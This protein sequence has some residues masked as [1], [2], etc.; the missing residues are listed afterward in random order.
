MAII[1]SFTTYSQLAHLGSRLSQSPSHVPPP[2]FSLTCPCQAGILTGDSSPGN[3]QTQMCI[4]EK[5]LACLQVINT[6]KTFLWQLSV[7]Y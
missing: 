2:P 6:L 1:V 7:H 5:D 4:E 3:R